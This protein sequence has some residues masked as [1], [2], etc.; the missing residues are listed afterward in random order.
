MDW[1]YL[2]QDCNKW[3]TVV[4]ATMNF[5]FPY[6]NGNLS[7]SWATISFSSTLL[8]GVTELVTVLPLLHYINSPQV[9]ICPSPYV[10]KVYKNKMYQTLVIKQIRFHPSVK[11]WEGAQQAQCHIVPAQQATSCY[12]RF[13]TNPIFSTEMQ[14]LYFFRIFYL[15]WGYQTIGQIPATQSYT[16]KQLSKIPEVLDIVNHPY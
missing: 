1:I 3:Q 4:N 14:F 7:T 9:L 12:P 15:F 5:W 11:M 2:A 16:G 10:P 13:E 6:N 8:Q